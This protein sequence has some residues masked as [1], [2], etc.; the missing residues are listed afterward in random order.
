MLTWTE[1][2]DG[3]GHYGATVTVEYDRWSPFDAERTLWHYR[4]TIGHAVA[5][6][7]DLETHGHRPCEALASLASFLSA[8]REA[9]RY[10]DSENRNLFGPDFAALVEAYGDDW[11]DQLS[12]E[13]DTES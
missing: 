1:M 11:I 3:N 6:G 4:V 2:H 9:Q 13:M 5:E 12:A 10:P 7:N 8:W